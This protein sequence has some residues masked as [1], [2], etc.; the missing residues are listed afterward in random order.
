MVA[1]VQPAMVGSAERCEGPNVDH[2]GSIAE[3]VTRCGFSGKMGVRR[4][5]LNRIGVADSATS[6]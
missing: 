4:L 3:E 2:E 1:R 6:D 5:A